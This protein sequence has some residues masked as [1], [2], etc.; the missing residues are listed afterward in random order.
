VVSLGVGRR[1][2]VSEP[3]V[4][5]REGLLPFRG[6]A[7]VRI[8]VAER[9]TSGGLSAAGFG[10]CTGFKGCK[11]RRHRKFGWLCGVELGL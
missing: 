10:S 2:G 7:E 11:T 4:S 1:F 5:A 9:D 8:A 6:I 3:Y